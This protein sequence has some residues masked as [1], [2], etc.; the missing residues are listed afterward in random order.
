MNNFLF[1]YD[2]NGRDLKKII[3]A[4]LKSWI[5]IEVKKL[6]Y[7][8]KFILSDKL[9]EKSEIKLLFIQSEDEEKLMTF[10]SKNFPQIKRI[11]VK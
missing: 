3:V 6:N 5:A 11:Y 4:I 9:V 10:L 1:V 7:G 2:W 8:H